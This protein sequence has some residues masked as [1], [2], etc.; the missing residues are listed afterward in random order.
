MSHS[1]YP[2]GGGVPRAKAMDGRDLG[3]HPE[4]RCGGLTSELLPIRRL[5]GSSS[6]PPKDR[7][8]MYLVLPDDPP[9]GEVSP[10]QLPAGC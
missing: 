1:V 4:G 8:G 3:C 10:E 2:R 6:V 7:L 5:I 9:R